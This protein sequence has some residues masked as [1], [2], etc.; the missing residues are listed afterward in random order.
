MT[1]VSANAKC[2]AIVLVSLLLSVL[3]LPSVAIACE[4][5]SEEVWLEGEAE[6]E[7]KALG[8]NCIFKK[9]K[10]VCAITTTNN[11]KFNLEWITNEFAGNKGKER[12]AFKKEGCE[13]TP[14]HLNTW[15]KGAKCTDSVE[16]VK[17][18][19]GTENKKCET[20]KIE[21]NGKEKTECPD[22]LTME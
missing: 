7:G 11:S 8:K 6:V 21:E 19:A 2:V 16:A 1:L 9:A 14:N 13:T 3:F 17:F 20:V 5:G 18:E 15:G 12:Y 22:S 10:D 4:G